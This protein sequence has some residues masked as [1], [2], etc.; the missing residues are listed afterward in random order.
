MDV[1]WCRPE[2]LDEAVA[3]PSFDVIDTRSAQGLSTPARSRFP[4]IITEWDAAVLDLYL[5]ATGLLC[6]S[7]KADMVALNE[8]V[9]WNWIRTTLGSAAPPGRTHR[10]SE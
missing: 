3:L 7:D 9:Q 2:W 4:A 5:I 8:A 6:D 1:D 10:C